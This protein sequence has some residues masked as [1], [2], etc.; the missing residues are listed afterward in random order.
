MEKNKL[1]KLEQTAIDIR[2]DCLNMQMEAKSG[3]LGGAFSAVEIMTYLYFELMDIDP[4]NPYKEDRDIFIIS[5]GHASLSYYSVLARRGFFPVEELSSYRKINTRLQGHTH[6]DSAPGVESSTGSLGQGLSFGLG[7]GLGYKK[8]DIGNNVY[9][10]L[11]DGEM[12]EGQIWEALMLN[13]S[14]Q[15]D[16]VIPIIDNNKIQL[17]DYSSNI[18]GEWKLKEKLEAF[19]YNVIEINGHDFNEIEKAF[20]SIK[21][22]RANVIIA[23]TIKG[24]GISFMEDKIQWHSKKMDENEYNI[25]LEELEKKEAMLNV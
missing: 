17:A 6:M 20:T 1:N 23:N 15:L 11:G 7:I 19:N 3:H 10:L 5:K 22:G 8:K 18:V 13:G 9:I 12:Q 25:A 2:R 4:L 16:N 21:K 24:K 14:L